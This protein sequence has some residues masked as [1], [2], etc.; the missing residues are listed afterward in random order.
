MILLRIKSEVTG[1]EE[2]LLLNV[3][4]LFVLQKRE[5]FVGFVWKQTFSSSYFFRSALS[6]Q[7]NVLTE[8][9]NEVF[10]LGSP[11]SRVYLHVAKHSDGVD[12]DVLLVNFKNEPTLLFR[13]LFFV[14]T[15]A[16]RQI[17]HK[18]NI[19]L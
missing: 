11:E 6:L 16:M 5:H 13:F 17:I 7:F 10:R 14:K 3:K 18:T 15:N 2:S 12:K 9:G 1:V 4:I 19:Y 8:E